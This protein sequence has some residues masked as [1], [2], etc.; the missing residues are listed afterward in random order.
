[1]RRG[2]CEAQIQ[3]PRERQAGEGLQREHARP[4][5]ADKPYH[6][7]VD[8]ERFGRDFHDHAHRGA[9]QP[10]RFPG[11]RAPRVE[12]EELRSPQHLDEH[13]RRDPGGDN[14]AQRLLQNRPWR[15]QHER[16]ERRRGEHDIGA[17]D[18]GEPAAAG[19]AHH[20]QRETDG[21]DHSRDRLRPAPA[22]PRS[23]LRTRRDEQE[24]RAGQADQAR[25]RP[26]HER[27]QGQERAPPRL[28]SVYAV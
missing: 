5:D 25:V 10:R 11:E 18:R 24:R 28:A 7:L 8:R 1:M 2:W 23:V 3:L 15:E 27:D 26:Q 19:A 9:R 16:D 12:S 4:G 22:P 21:A 20:Q 6:R 14:R 17:R 13:R